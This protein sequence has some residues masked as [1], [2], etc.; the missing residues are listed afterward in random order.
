[1][2]EIIETYKRLVNAGFKFWVKGE[3]L[4]VFPQKLLTTEMTGFIQAHKKELIPLINSLKGLE[5]EEAELMNQA[6]QMFRGEVRL[7][8]GYTDPVNKLLSK[9]QTEDQKKEEILNRAEYRKRLE[10]FKKGDYSLA[11]VPFRKQLKFNN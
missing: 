6:T 11:K 8:D 9:E 7:P 5:P 10:A 1:M 2:S 4:S 3:A